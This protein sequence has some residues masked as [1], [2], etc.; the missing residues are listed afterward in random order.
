MKVSFE[1]IGEQTATFYNDAANPAAS[2][3]A[4]KLSANA[5]A[6]LCADGEDFAGF[7]AAADAATAAVQTA[8]FVTAFYTGTA[9]AV[10]F[11]ALCADAAGGVKT[12]GDRK[13]LVVETDAAAKTVGFI[14]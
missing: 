12:G 4:V 6:A 7:C 9:P 8:G 2:G 10:G 5:T 1:G 3:K 11:C 14:M 13:Y